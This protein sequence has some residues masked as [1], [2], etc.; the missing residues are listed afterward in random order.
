MQYSTRSGRKH[1]L[2][3]AMAAAMAQAMTLPASASAAVS[4][5][6]L[7][8][9]IDALQ[10]QVTALN[11]EVQ[12]AAEWKNP[13]TLVH[14]AGYAN[15]GYAKTD[16]AGD[17]GSFSGGTFA[18]IFHY[19]YRDIVML[20]A[21]M[22]LS[23]M[24]NG[25]AESRLEYLTIDWFATDNITVV[26]GQFLSPIGQF[27]QNLH[28]SWINKMASAAPGFGHDGAAPI[29]DIGVQ[30]RGGFHLGG[31][32]ANY[33][34]YVANGP[35]IKAEVEDDGSGGVDA[36]EYDGIA[37]EAFGA[38]RDGNKVFGGRLGL[39]PVA[40]LEIGLSFISGKAKVTEYEDLDLSLF[41]TNTAPPDL[42]S[43]A[44][45]ASSY[46]VIGADVSWRNRN[47]DVRFEYVKSE[48]GATAIGGFGLEA[49][50]W[51][52]WYAQY[53]YKF[54][55]TRVEAAIRYGDFDS[56]GAAKDVQQTAVGLN[57]LFTNNFIGKIT[58]ESNDNPN[59]GFNAD[60]RW[61]LQLAYGF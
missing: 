56:P 41:N 35:E 28:P 6:E 58:Y 34:V 14:M 37:A 54:P 38:D 24:E 39:L 19:Q 48:L 60:N 22:E 53:A 13:N 52:T 15:V 49:A 55:G 30:L 36:I 32:K 50:A 20:E 51:S 25:E 4:S 42:D 2:T 59:A 21:E 33:A 40:S 29:A 46:D 9:Q 43:T 47:S 12:Q 8:Q 17:K 3:L 61:L 44:F 18:P 16:A 10:R 1:A 45:A 26:A 5:S 31:M 57:Y 11:S 27:R 7:Q 23:T